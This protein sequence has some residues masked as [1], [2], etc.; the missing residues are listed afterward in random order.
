M[1]ISDK[2][3]YKPGAEVIKISSCSTQLSIAFILLIDVKMPTIV[4]MLTFISRV[5]EC[6]LS[7]KHEMSI[8]C[9]YFTIH[10]QFKFHAQLS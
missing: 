4:G 1:G 9:G 7:L 3:R 6:L 8:D 10:E 2:A 5:N